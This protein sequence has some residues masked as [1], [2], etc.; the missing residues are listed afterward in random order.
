MCYDQLLSRDKK[1]VSS[2]YK[3]FQKKNPFEYKL[4][5]MKNMYTKDCVFLKNLNSLLILCFVMLQ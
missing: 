3:V 4:T 5:E 1:M 2:M